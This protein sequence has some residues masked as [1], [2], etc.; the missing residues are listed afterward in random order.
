MEE[1]RTSLRALVDLDCAAGV[2]HEAEI[3]EA[4]EEAIETELGEPSQALLDELT[5]RALDALEARARDEANWVARTVNDRI[6]SAFADLDARGIV[7]AQALG[8]T[9]QE[10]AWLIDRQCGERAGEV[11]GS[12]FYHRQDLERGVAGEG[13]L[14]AFTGYAGAAEPAA[15]GR[16]IV[17]VLQHH[18]VP[19]AW[20]GKVQSRIEIPPFTWQKRRVTKA[21]PG[22]GPAGPIPPPAPPPRACP[23]CGGRGWVTLDPMRGSELCACKLRPPAP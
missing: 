14:L 2:Y 16:E 1:L 6:D 3:L 4:I 20:N 17:Y 9:V 5:T 8:F 21:P 23:H 15:I 10:G 18:G 22:A 12:V 7:A 13:L 19:V 11:R